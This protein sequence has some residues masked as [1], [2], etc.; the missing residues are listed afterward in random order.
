MVIYLNTYFLSSYW[1]D[2]WLFNCGQK[3]QANISL[4]HLPFLSLA[5]AVP[6]LHFP[7]V[8]LWY[9]VCRWVLLLC[10]LYCCHICCLYICHHLPNQ[11]GTPMMDILLI[12]DCN[13]ESAIYSTSY[14]EIL[15]L[16]QFCLPVITL[17]LVSG[18][19]LLCRDIYHFWICDNF[20]LL[21]GSKGEMDK[22]RTG[23]IFLDFCITS[24]LLMMTIRKYI[25]ITNILY[26]IFQYL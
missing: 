7:D 3:T 13:F 20:D 22:N 11:K 16:T 2:E 6:F 17:C 21:I 14:F 24:F 4:V 23:L 1:V 18:L 26:S 19:S 12:P 9:L 25:K 8:Q 5:G 15:V 10:Q